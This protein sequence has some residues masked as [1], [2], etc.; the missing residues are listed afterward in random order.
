MFI[1]LEAID[2]IKLMPSYICLANLGM[3][4]YYIL[5]YIVCMLRSIYCLT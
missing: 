2:V 5:L 3:P 4:C 1:L